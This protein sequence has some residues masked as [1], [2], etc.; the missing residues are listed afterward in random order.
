M[1]ALFYAPL[2]L[3][4]ILVRK[5]ILSKLAVEL[6]VLL[7]RKRLVQHRSYGAPARQGKQTLVRR[8]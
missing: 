7:S 3:A 8:K 4:K 1:R 5:I 2:I 6:S